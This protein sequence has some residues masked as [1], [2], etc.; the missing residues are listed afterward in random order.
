ML[1]Y[2]FQD[3]GPILLFTSKRL[4]IGLKN[5]DLTDSVACTATAH[6]WASFRMPDYRMPAVGSKSMHSAYR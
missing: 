2:Q 1:T 6:Q 5:D 3:T 4:K